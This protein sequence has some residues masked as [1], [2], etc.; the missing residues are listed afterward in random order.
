[1]FVRQGFT[2]VELL[3]VIVLLSI[4]SVV[5][6]SRSVGASAFEAAVLADFVLE[7]ARFAQRLA[8]YRQDN[9]VVLRLAA[10]A[11][12]IEA[13]IILSGTTTTR[14]R[15]W[16]TSARLS[17]GASTL[18]AGQAAT[19]SFSGEGEVVAAS[20]AGSIVDPTSGIQ[21]TAGGENPRTLCL[22][23]SGYVDTDVCR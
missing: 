13:D 11:Q 3:A 6:L 14:E 17:L 4:L 15:N 1:M 5:A 16:D 10:T 2:I 21:I 22:Y 12:G 23:P 9:D 8:A 18:S 7:E 20:W 19:L